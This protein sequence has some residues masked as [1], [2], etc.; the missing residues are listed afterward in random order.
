MRIKW[1]GYGGAVDSKVCSQMLSWVFKLGFKLLPPTPGHFPSRGVGS[2]QWGERCPE[3]E[4]WSPRLGFY[5]CKLTSDLTFSL[6]YKGD[7]VGVSWSAGKINGKA[8]WKVLVLLNY[9][10]GQ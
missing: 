7:Q 10:F 8:L 5:V 1:C 4:A 9:S 3:A 6:V 2:A